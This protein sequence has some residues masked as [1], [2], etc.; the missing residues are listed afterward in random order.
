MHTNQVQQ[1][2]EGHLQDGWNCGV[3]L[4]AGEVLMPAKSRHS[5]KLGVLALLLLGTFAAAPVAQACTPLER[6]MGCV[7]PPLPP[8]PGGSS[9]PMVI[10]GHLAAG[11]ALGYNN[12]GLPDAEMPKAV[13]L[14]RST[15]ANW[16]RS[17]VGWK[18]EQTRNTDPLLWDRPRL[19]DAY[20]RLDGQMMILILGAPYWAQQPCSNLLD[21]NCTKARSV[22]GQWAHHSPPGDAYID[23]YARVARLVA[24]RYPQAIVETW[25][26][27]NLGWFWSPDAISPERMARMQCAAYDAVKAQSPT[28]LVAAPGISATT[29]SD[30]NNIDPKKRSMDWRDYVRRMYVAMGRV[31]WDVFSVHP[32]T[33]SVDLDRAGDWLSQFYADLRAMRSQYGDQSRVFLT[34]LGAPTSGESSVTEQQ[35]RD[36]ILRQTAKHLEQPEVE[37]VFIHTLHNAPFNGTDANREAHFGVF[38]FDDSPKPA[39]CALGSLILGI[40]PDG[41]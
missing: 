6:L 23:D 3:R 2:E 21:L 22:N 34:E 25:N 35:Q 11:K 38:R 32:Y 33:T 14:L 7:D 1:I 39:A 8:D 24:E 12:T 29:A 28:T 30:L 40:A 37:G 31:C 17:G 20:A 36:I 26:E 18:A 16:L 27:P 5:R 15:G 4:S 41:C 13:A 10:P 19:D 9:N